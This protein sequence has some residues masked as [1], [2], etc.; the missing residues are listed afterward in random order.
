MSIFASNGGS[1][2]INKPPITA[3]KLSA[4]NKKHVAT[5]TAPIINPAIDGPT[6]RAPLTIELLSEIA[7][8]KSSRLVISTVKDCRAGMSNPIAM[9]LSAAMMT[10]KFALA[11]PAQMPIAR[12]NAQI[13]CAI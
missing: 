10:M 1:R 12:R 8:N 6:T 13:I 5:P 7:F 11:N 4:L 9:P 3:T 2:I